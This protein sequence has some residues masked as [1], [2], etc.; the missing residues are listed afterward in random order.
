MFV[1][2][3]GMFFHVPVI[4]KWRCWNRVPATIGNIV[5]GALFTGAL[6]FITYR[7]SPPR[8]KQAVLLESMT[9]VGL[10]AEGA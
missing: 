1:L 9:P 8:G 6:L 3:A 4:G 5:S 7:A 2:P 10:A